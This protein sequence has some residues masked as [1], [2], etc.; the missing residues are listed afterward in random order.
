MNGDLKKVTVVKE[1][2]K[3]EEEEEEK[4]RRRIVAIHSGGSKG[5]QLQFYSGRGADCLISMATQSSPQ[6]AEEEKKG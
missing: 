4:E 1:Q 6:E 2:N 5:E 3:K